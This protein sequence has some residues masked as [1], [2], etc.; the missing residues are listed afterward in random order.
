M[1][2]KVPPNNSDSLVNLKADLAPLF[3]K[4]NLD[5]KWDTPSLPVLDPA[6]L[7]ITDNLVKSEAD[8]LAAILT[9]FGIEL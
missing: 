5:N 9:E 8:S 3:K 7:M 2:S 6:L 4:V 1:D